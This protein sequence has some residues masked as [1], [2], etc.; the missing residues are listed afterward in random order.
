M[1]FPDGRKI[2]KHQENPFDNVFINFATWINPYLRRV[3]VTPNMITYVSAIFGI[4]VALLL[5][6]GWYVTAGIFFLTSYI[7]D[8]MDGNM[9]RMYNMVTDYGDKLDHVTDMIQIMCTIIVIVIHPV[10]TLKVKIIALIVI[11]LSMF[12]AFIHIGCQEKSYQK[13]TTDTLSSF[14][15]LCSDKEMIKYTRFIG[16]GTAAIVISILFVYFKM[17]H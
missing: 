17:T 14:E 4:T 5:Y 7:L 15:K 3:G 12:G 16:T 13:Q 2:P 9:A 1:A 6:N 8:C 11:G 10:F